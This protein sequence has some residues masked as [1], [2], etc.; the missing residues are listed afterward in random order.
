MRNTCAFL[1]CGL[2]SFTRFLHLIS[3]ETKFSKKND[4]EI[5]ICISIF[6]K[7]NFWNIYYVKCPFFCQIS[8]LEVFR[9][10]FQK[11]FKYEIQWKSV[12]WEPSCYLWTNRRLDGGWTGRHD[13]V[14]SRFSLFCERPP[15]VRYVTWLCVS[16]TLFTRL[17]VPQTLYCPYFNERP[18]KLLEIKISY[19]PA[20]IYRKLRFMWST[21]VSSY[22]FYQI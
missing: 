17:H 19:L 7:K 5:K 1:Y 4:I 8:N 12:Q 11:V 2:L 16:T 18:V 21:T 3:K 9:Q 20:E 22:L 15:K 14:N 6:S 13:E 10:I